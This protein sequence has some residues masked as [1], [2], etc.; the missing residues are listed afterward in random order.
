MPVAH[1]FFDLSAVFPEILQGLL[2]SKGGGLRVVVSTAAFHARAR[3]SVPGLGGLKKTFV[4]SPST[5]K[6]QYCGEPPWPNIF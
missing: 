1:A 2:S 3:G 5:P 6:T 4:S